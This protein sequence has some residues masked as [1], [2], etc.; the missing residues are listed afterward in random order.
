M[1]CRSRAVLLLRDGTTTRRITGRRG[2]DMDRQR[3]AADFFLIAHDEF[4]G[5]LRI[6]PDLLRL[7]ARRRPARRADHG[8]AGWPS[9]AAGCSSREVRGAATRSAHTSPRASPAR[10]STHS[11]R[12][13]VDT[14]RRG[15]LRA[16]RPPAGRRG[17]GPP[18]AGRPPADAQAPRPF[19]RHGPAGRRPPP[20][21]PGAHAAHPAGV[22]PA[23]RDPRRAGRRGRCR[24][25]ARPARSTGRPRA[26]CSA[27]LEENCPADVRP[28]VEG[29][30][31]AVA[32]VSL[33]VR[34]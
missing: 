10:R 24:D 4:S 6:S 11:V 16:G 20:A 30:R 27:R 7:R 31:A 14:F 5:K 13:W 2:P 9:R 1:I 34:R 8:E 28:L 12:V 26:S 33:T 23:G 29:V 25:R 19:P 21:A 15:A 18:R 22:R 3:L 17:R 32:A